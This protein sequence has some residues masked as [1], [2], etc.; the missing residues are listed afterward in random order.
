MFALEI[1]FKGAAAGSE[2]VF[3]RRP[4]ALIG[5]QE[6]AHVVLDDLRDL[7][8]QIR[9]TRELG[10]QFRLSPIVEGDVG[11]VPQFLDGV[12]DG[13]A[14]VDL[15]P[16]ALRLT[17]LDI[18]LMMKET[19]T[20]DRAGV[21]I[22][23]QA[24]GGMAAKF[25]ALVMTGTPAVT[26]SFLPD[27]PVLIGRARD[28]TLRVDVQSISSKHA[29]IGFE[30]GE[31]WVE[32][33]GSTNG[34]FV[35][36]QQIAGRVNVPA[37][38]AIRFGEDVEL[39]GVVSADQ[40]SRAT[41]GK[42]E[43]QRKVASVA[44]NKFPIL[45]SLS[46]SAR[47]A[48]I[49]LNPGD[50]VAM[51]RDPASDMWLGAPHISRRHCV[52]EMTK[53]G[54]VRIEDHSTNGTAYD[55]GILHKGDVV[56]T[57]STPYVLDFGGSVS[58]AL[59]F[60]AEDEAIFVKANGSPQSFVAQKVETSPTPS[61]GTQGRRPRRTTTWLRQP[62]VEQAVATRDEPKLGPLGRLYDSLSGQG[63]FVMIAA[64]IGAAGVL[65]LIVSLLL[66]VVGKR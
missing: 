42:G 60:S 36:K 58:V 22:L 28:C 64:V 29:R 65:S 49:V 7:N 9:I 10:R 51:G 47:P 4:T 41:S 26:I 52:V 20:P 63:R 25:P 17:A 24:C 53:S 15:G 61:K 38:V 37:G 14:S 1:I 54:L 57:N 16:V 27:V 23:R 66:P 11:S 40:L 56:E 43:V 33:L 32:D 55:G 19:E 46:E 6:K 21:R 8:Y 59:C 2:T 13:E 44:E 35:H 3:I 45:V 18:D 62:E 30:S 12:Y 5:A 34:T 48:R 31:F 50:S 39:I